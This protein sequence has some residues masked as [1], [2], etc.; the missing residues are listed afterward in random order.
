[1]LQIPSP[2]EKINHPLFEEKKITIFVKR[3]DLIHPEISGNKWR[4]LKFN[5]EEAKKQHKNL[6]LTFG[7]AYSN[8]I[9][10]TAAVGKLFGLKTIGV[11]RGEE[12]S[13]L[14]PT[15]E[16]AQKD[17][18]VLHYVSRTDY[19]TKTEP[20]FI[21]NLRLLFGDFYL[22][23]EGGCNNLGAKGC[24]E[25]VNEIEIDFDYILTDCGTGTTLA[26][27]CKAL[28]PNQKAIGIP[29]LKGGDFI[30]KEV[31]VLLGKSYKNIKN[32]YCLKTNYH[33]GG[34]AKYKPE[35]ID[36]M[37]DF[38]NETG[39]KTD[40]IYTG[41]LFYAFMDLTQQNHFKEGSKIVII[42]TGGLQGIEGFEKRHCFSIF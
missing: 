16:Q 38:H 23:P 32:Q 42:H 6:I 11:I 15:L 10:A 25:I 17:G 29:V 8:H 22:I 4:K 13:P 40:P 5:L 1:M 18:M 37:R 19:R 33:F 31:E 7:G 41:K 24:Q 14:N 21:E 39:I 20:E 26:G 9:A 3:D 35:L 2:I 30:R 36:F 28:S 12:T 27:I 34:Y